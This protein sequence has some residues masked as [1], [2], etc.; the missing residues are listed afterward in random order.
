MVRECP[1]RGQRHPAHAGGKP[2]GTHEVRLRQARHDDHRPHF[3]RRLTH[4]RG[5]HDPVR[6][7]RFNGQGHRRRHRHDRHGSAGDRVPRDRPAVRLRRNDVGH[8]PDE[9]ED[10]GRDDPR[11]DGRHDSHQ[12]HIR[13]G[14][15][16]SHVFGGLR[17]RDLHEPAGGVFRLGVRN[18]R[19]R[20]RPGAGVPALA[21]GGY[22]VG[23]DGPD[24]EPGCFA[25]LCHG[26]LSLG[27]DW[28]SHDRAVAAGF[29]NGR[30]RRPES[31]VPGGRHDRLPLA[32]RPVPDAGGWNEPDAPE[33]G[34]GSRRAL[35]PRSGSDDRFRG[36]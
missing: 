28:R 8:H 27:G 23:S 18:A 35:G 7:G 9:P 1:G 17:Q 29:R 21:G 4:D 24:S 32:G 3:G 22:R 25:D 31:L 36:V 12:L 6:A 5:F 11:G 16:G 19:R 30:H 14:V 13:G 33:P 34:I 10:G 20:R 2:V 26:S 15:P